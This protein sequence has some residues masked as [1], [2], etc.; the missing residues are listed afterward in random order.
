MKLSKEKPIVQISS[1][2]AY[3]NKWLR[4]REDQTLRAQGEGIY[5]VVE[6][7]DS[8]VICAVNESKEVY[9]IYGYSYPTDTWSWQIPGG[10]GD[11]QDPKIAAARELEEETGLIAEKYQVL[12]DLIVSSG[13]LKERMAV[14]VATGLQESTRPA[15]ADDIDV[16]DEG[17]FVHFTELANKI[18]SGEICDSQSISAIYLLEKWIK[19]YGN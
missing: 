9:L 15:S 7:Q 12:G 10:G 19:S 4:V 1:R 16:I 11:G 6:T 5:G 13:L 18:L 3:E 8:V 17:K 2:I 14:V